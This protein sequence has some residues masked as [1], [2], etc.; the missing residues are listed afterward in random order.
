MGI[1]PCI[2]CEGDVTKPDGKGEVNFRLV[3]CLVKGIVYSDIYIG[4][5]CVYMLGYV[6][7]YEVTWCVGYYGV[8]C[9]M[10]CALWS[11]AFR[12]S[13]RKVLGNI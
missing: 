5:I 2:P 6:C 4:S 9:T 7:M 12:E 10:V 8:W 3:E 13:S 11:R 1:P